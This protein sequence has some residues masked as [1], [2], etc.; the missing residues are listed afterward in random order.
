MLTPFKFLPGILRAPL[1]ALRR[2]VPQSAG[3]ALA[4]FCI[5]VAGAAIA[6]LTQILLAR[7]LGAAEYGL[8]VV[9]YVWITILSQ[10]GNLGFSSAAIRFVPEYRTRNEPALLRGF[11]RVSRL[12]A[13]AFSSLFLI[14]GGVAVAVAPTGLFPSNTAVLLA[15][16]LTLPLFCL[17]EVQ[18]GLARAYNWISLAFG[19]TY[20]WRPLLIIAL[21]AAALG[22]GIEATALTACIVTAVATWITALTQAVA[23]WRR[24]PVE[25]GP[26]AY[27]LRHWFATALPILAADGF[28]VLLTSVDVVMVSWLAGPKEV[29]IYYAATKTLALV[30]FVYYAVRAASG[31]RFSALFHGGQQEDL[32]RF[33]RQTVRWTFWPSVGVSIV[34]L[35][36]GRLLL[37]LFGGDFVEGS[38]VLAILVTGILA[39][40]SVGTSETLLTMAGHQRAVAGIFGIAFLCNLLFCSLLI[41]QF[42]L[43]GAATGTALSLAVEAGL[44]ATAVHKYFDISVWIFHPDNW[45]ARPAGEERADDEI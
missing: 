4:A 17:T 40:A 38:M 25:A 39:R 7:W 28:Y 43:L 37:S 19:P 31:P 21:L 30:H 9:I 35:A 27:D 14:A 11:L 41:P 2:A 26:A 18:D 22:A 44:V 15:G 34:V 32:A 24:H 20:I 1:E 5:R 13:L 8:Y 36:F 6:Y 29:A 16:G 12:S 23:I 45:S 10:I 42:G 33:V 3:T